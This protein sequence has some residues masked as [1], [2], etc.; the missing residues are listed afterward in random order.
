MSVASLTWGPIYIGVVFNILLFG[1]MLTQTYLYFN[2]YKRDKAWMKLLVGFL[3]LCDTLNTGFDIALPYV[4]LISQYGDQSVLNNATWIARTDPAMTAIIA[5]VVQWFF[6]WRIKV[7]TTNYPTVVLIVICSFA[8]FCGGIG[9]A[10]AVGIVPQFSSFQKFKVIVIIWLGFSALADALIMF[11]LVWHLRKNRTGF[12]KTDD[13]INRI[14]RLTVQT[15]MLTTVCALVDLIL[16]LA[17]PTGVHLIFNL[18]LS[19]L[20]T[21]SLMSSLNS[22]AGWGYSTGG[23]STHDHG[24][25]RETH[26]PVALDGN[27]VTVINGSSNGNHT[28][29]SQQVVI[30]VETSRQVFVDDESFE[31]S[32]LDKDTKV[33]NGVHPQAYSADNYV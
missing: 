29:S 24:L 23:V 32:S 20:H 5:L 28:K 9:T 3:V 19:K 31:M 4:P 8:Q 10:I 13:T 30:G 15:G 16:Y 18:P 21:N 7:L 33:A 27:R 17:S 22:R 1:I 26:K 11:G 6:A 14:I 25:Q 12:A 2:T